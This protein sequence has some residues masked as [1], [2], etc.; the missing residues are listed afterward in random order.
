MLYRQLHHPIHHHSNLKLSRSQD[1]WQY[2]HKLNYS[3]RSGATFI[4]TFSYTTPDN[5]LLRCDMT[6]SY[7][8]TDG[9]TS[10]HQINFAGGAS[11]Y[12]YDP[13]DHNTIYIGSAALN[14]SVDGGRTWNQIFPLKTDV[15]GD[16][17]LGD[18]ADYSIKT[19]QGSLYAH[20]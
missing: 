12:A 2:R 10:F 19:I 14:R 15:R 11:S 7:L 13:G 4:P 20:E 6:G 16:L 17:Y 3:S 5:F 1:R 18:H 8:T 9:G